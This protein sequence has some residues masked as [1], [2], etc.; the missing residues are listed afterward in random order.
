MHWIAPKY[1][2]GIKVKGTN[3]LATYPGGAHFYLFCSNM[4]SSQ[5]NCNFSCSYWPRYVSNIFIFIWE[6]MFFGLWKHNFWRNILRTESNNGGKS[7]R[8][9]GR[10][11]LPFQLKKKLTFPNKL[12]IKHSMIDFVSTPSFSISRYLVCVSSTYIWSINTGSDPLVVTFWNVQSTI[13][14]VS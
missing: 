1:P 14:E 4:S 12:E 9:F 5:D 3:T 8:I 6:W 2:L 11:S 7:S 10:I 13:T